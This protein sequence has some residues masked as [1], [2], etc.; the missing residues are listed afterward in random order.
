V[1]DLLQMVEIIIRIRN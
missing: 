1:S